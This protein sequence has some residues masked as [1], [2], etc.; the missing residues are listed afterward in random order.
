VG[1]SRR[2]NN[3]HI[4]QPHA[5]PPFTTTYQVTLTDAKGCTFQDSVQVAVN[6][7]PIV[8]LDSTLVVCL[9]TQ[10]QLT[11]K[12]TSTAAPLQYRWSPSIGLSNAWVEQPI[13]TTT[14]SRWYTLTV[15]DVYK[16]VGIDSIFVRVAPFPLVD[17]G[18]DSSVCR[19]DSVLIGHEATGGTPPFTYQWT[20]A[21]GLAHA[22]WA[23][24]KASPGSSQLYHL[25]VLDLNGCKAEDSVQVNIIPAPLPVITASGR[26][27]FLSRRQR[28]PF[29]NKTVSPI[30][31]VDGRQFSIDTRA[32]RRNLWRVGCGLEWLRRHF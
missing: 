6:V 28:P 24:A 4:A 10:P 8:D 19:G 20:P 15:T 12:I 27:T 32:R 16:C 31:V 18:H 30:P 3:T 23:V 1:S 26:L 22:D 2:L 7:P 9:N 29:N 5:S 13:L 14:Q 25:T 11:P 17:A 21:I